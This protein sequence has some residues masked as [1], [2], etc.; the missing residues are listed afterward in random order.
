[1]RASAETKATPWGEGGP[2]LAFAADVDAASRAE[3]VAVVGGWGPELFSGGD[4]EVSV[5]LGGANN[6][7]FVVR[8]PTAKYA[9]RI[10]NQQN[11]RFAVDRAS[12]IQAQR[13]AAAGGLAPAV[14]A[15]ELPA[16]HVLSAFV[17]G[18]TLLG[19]GQLRDREVLTA[20]GATLR[21]LHGTPSS[22]RAF[23]PFDDIRLW[24]QLARDDG[25][26]TPD[27]LDELL[28]SAWQIESMVRDAGLPAVFCHND[29]VPQ[30]FILS[31]SELCLVD[32]D[33]AGRGWA[34]FELASFCATADLGPELQEVLVR[35]YDERTS[36]AQLATVELLRFVA[37]M[38][39]A[40]WALMAAPILQGE[41]TPDD[42]DFYAN[43]LRDYLR[44]ARERAGASDFYALMKA[45]AGGGPRE[46]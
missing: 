28:G 44:L 5:L 6:R 11:E 15:S 23:S 7:N 4:A 39:E 10:A 19:A 3:I 42:D 45:A 17:E 43:Y 22:I 38:R 37:A 16:G 18:V 34:C 24:A 12:A 46:W 40:T 29:T 21:R 26:E 8:T 36:E 2:A 41:T 9:L 30:N 13:D 33:Y 31:G 32:W 20:V 1:V 14:V 27:D 25:T 35:S